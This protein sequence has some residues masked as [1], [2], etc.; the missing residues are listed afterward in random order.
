M[1]QDKGAVTAAS[2]GTGAL[3]GAV[4]GWPGK[5]AAVTGLW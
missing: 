1:R 3:L 4:G 2:P 5:T